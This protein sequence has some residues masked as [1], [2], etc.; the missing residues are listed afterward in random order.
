M[1]T[2]E[3]NGNDRRTNKRINMRA[4]THTRAY[5]LSCVCTP[6]F[7][8]ARVPLF[9]GVLILFALTCTNFN[10]KLDAGWCFKFQ[11]GSK[12]SMLPLVGFTN[13]SSL[14]GFFATEAMNA[15]L[16]DAIRLF[17]V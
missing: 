14:N 5:Y 11:L 8:F 3:N 4:H 9:I 15:R 10:A 12:S 7:R 16:A 17:A 1:Y 6:A 2:R 13:A